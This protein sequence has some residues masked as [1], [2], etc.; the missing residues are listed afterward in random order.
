MNFIAAT[1]ELKS[2]SPD[3]ITA[4][5]LNYRGA[6]AAVPAGN[7]N[8]E[9]RFRLL[10]YDREGAK[11]TSFT[12]WAPGTRALITGNIVF[13]DDP[14]QPLDLIVSTIEPNVPQDMYCNQVV[15]GNA[16]FGSDEIRERKTG[17]LA[18]KIGTTLDN[19]DVTTWLYLETHESRKKKLND[20]IRKGRAICVQGY[21][22][23]YRK[24]DSDSPYRAIVATDFTT[25]KEQRKS[26]S[27]P[28]TN[29]SASGYA[30]V[31]PTPD[32]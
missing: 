2:L 15:L 9:V 4:Y 19:S 31:D 12:N 8:G 28:A 5:G 23:E 29:G 20:R 1:I 7:S 25:R 32:Y 17:Q 3:Q 26:R 16:F 27:N 6:D 14:K 22:R 24:D 18:V 10:C 30:E 21:L 11:L 13:S